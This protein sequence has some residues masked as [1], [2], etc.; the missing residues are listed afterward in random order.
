MQY[1]AKNDLVQ[2]LAIFF[3]KSL[4]TSFLAICK[5]L[6]Y[7][8]LICKRKTSYLENCRRS[9]PYN[10]GTLYAIFCQK[11]TKFKSWYFFDKL[12]EIK[13]LAICTPLIYVQLICKR[14]TS[15]LENCRR[16]YPYNE[17]TLLAAA[18]PPAIFTILITG[19]FCWKTRL[20]M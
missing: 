16:S 17:G 2:E 9:Y 4:E 15:Y 12:S 3:K 13:I 1:F 19:F 7:V 11:M 14:T 6:I 8:Q 10:K 20:K 18:L 5:P